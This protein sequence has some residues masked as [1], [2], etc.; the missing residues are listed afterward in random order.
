LLTVPLTMKTSLPLVVL[1]FCFLGLT[2]RAQPSGNPRP[3]PPASWIMPDIA[4][5]NL[6]RRTFDSKAAG[7][8]V[9]YLLYLPPGYEKS[10]A[11]RYPVVY[12]LHGL[13]GSQQGAPDFCERLTQ[14]I[15]DGKAPPMIV[16]FVNGMI[17]SFYCDSATQRR[18]VETIIIKELI[19]HIDATCRTIS[20][21]EGRAIEGFSMGGFGAGH[22]GFKY[23]ELFGTVSMIDAALVSLDTMQTRHADIFASV[24]DRKADA[25]TAAHPV[26]LAVKNADVLKTGTFIRQITGPLHQPNEVLHEKL[27]ALGIPHDYQYISG[28]PHSPQIIYAHLGDANWAFYRKAFAAVSDTKT[29]HKE[30]GS[31]AGAAK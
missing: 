11:T 9:S 5:P 31:P 18:P 21:R 19:P 28:V 8:K 17:D 20:K 3:R 27:T 4:G 24:F 22:L 6:A 15:A 16:V 10:P 7:E 30:P 25:F 29:S 2:A 26:T 12:W 23:P 1:L 14:A 13:G